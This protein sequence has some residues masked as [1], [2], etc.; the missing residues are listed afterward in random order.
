MPLPMRKLALMSLF[1][2]YAM[3][4]YW[5]Y[6]IYAIGRSVYG[7]ADATSSGFHAAV[8]TNGEVAAFYNGVAFV[9]AFAM[10]PLARRIGAAPL[11]AAC[12]VITGIGMMVMPHMTSKAMLFLPAIGIGLGWASMMGNPY[13]ILAGSIPP[14]RTGVYMG[15]FNM[16]IVIPMLIFGVTLPLFY[17]SWLGGDPR[18]VLT[19]CGVLMLLAAVSVYTVRARNAQGL[20]LGA[21]PQA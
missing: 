15:I 17:Q 1:Q 14:E 4:A 13:V 6:V 7:T 5:N 12:L 11:H 18:N 16:M 8:L 3:M 21:A 10:V 9:A 19:L 20:P 2:W